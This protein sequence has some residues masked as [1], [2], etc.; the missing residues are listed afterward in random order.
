MNFRLLAHSN[1]A[2]PEIEPP[3]A[4]STSEAA[5]ETPDDNSKAS[6]S[7][8]ATPSSNDAKSLKCDV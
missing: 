3:A 4:E 7:T 5:A 2:E 8:E 1:D 6:A